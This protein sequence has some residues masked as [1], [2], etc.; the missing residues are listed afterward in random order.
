MMA[1]NVGA[2]VNNDPETIPITN[3]NRQQSTLVRRLT[4]LFRGRGEDEEGAGVSGGYV[5]FGGMNNTTSSNSSSSEQRTLGTFS[6]DLCRI[7]LN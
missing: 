2:S 1:S 7:K 3:P 4:R 5:G 6:G